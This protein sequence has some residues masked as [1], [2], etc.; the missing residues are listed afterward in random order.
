MKERTRKRKNVRMHVRVR[1]RERMIANGEY[2]KYVKVKKNKNYIVAHA[3][4]TEI[5]DTFYCRSFI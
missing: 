1:V 3:K 2:V 5:M 4:I